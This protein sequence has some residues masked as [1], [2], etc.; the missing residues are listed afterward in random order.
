MSANKCIALG[1]VPA[2]KYTIHGQQSSSFKKNVWRKHIAPEG[3]VH[4]PADLSE[5][6][7]GSLSALLC[8]KISSDF[9]GSPLSYRLT[10]GL[11]SCFKKKK[12]MQVEFVRNRWA[13]LFKPHDWKSSHVTTDYGSWLVSTANDDS[14]R[15]FQVATSISTLRQPM[16]PQILPS[17]GKESSCH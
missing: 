7:E 4:C 9:P 12:I 10:L 8:T 16:A 17:Q 13:L 3:S 14:N 15:D 6:V 1:A 11:G 5:C 2:H